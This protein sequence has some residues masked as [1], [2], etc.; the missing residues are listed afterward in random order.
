MSGE[1]EIADQVKRAKEEAEATKEA[2]Q[3]GKALR[4]R[5]FPSLFKV[6]DGR[7]WRE[8]E[9]EEHDGEVRKRWVPFGSEIRILAR[10]RTNAGEDHGLYLEVIDCDGVAHPW[11]MPAALLAGSGESIRAELLR[12]GFRPMHSAGRKWRDWLY[13]YLLSAD[14]EE[15]ARCVSSIGWHGTVFVLPDE[16]FSAGGEPERVVLQSAPPLNHAYRIQ[17]TLEDWRK[18]VA[19]PA[20]GNSRLILA[21]SAAFASPL[22]ALTDRSGFGL[23]LRGASSVGKST[24]LQVA[25]SVWGGGAPRDYVRSW[26]AT[27]NALEAVSAMHD[28]TI[29]CLDELAQVEPKAAGQA[30][31]ML[32]DGAGKMRAG[33]EGQARPGYTWRLIFLS[34][35]E[36][37]LADK[38]KEGD[39]QNAAGMEVRLVD[40]RADAGKSLGLFEDIHGAQD[41]GIFAQNISAA[42]RQYYGTAAREFLR[43]VVADLDKVKQEL[44]GLSQ[45]FEA[46]ALQENPG[47]DGQV[48]RVAAR[49]ALIAAAGDV[50]SALGI[51]GWPVGTAREACLR[52]FKDWLTERGG[53]GSGEEADARRRLIEAIETYGASRFQKWHVNSDRAVITPRWGFVK[54]HA[55]GEEHLESYQF[56]LTGPALKE[57]L[58]GLDFRAMVAALLG[59]GIVSQGAKAGSSKV[60]H[61]PN[62]GGKHRL[63]Q[64]DQD[65]LAGGESHGDE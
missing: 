19:S 35:G 13:E 55:E 38:I 48:K 41:A 60:F 1:K 6:A 46:V 11:S 57:I 22:L 25:A 26:R 40:L 17:G 65:A 49:F 4:K 14:P 34:T 33:K 47:A 59:K 58:R 20:L 28:G 43:Y 10:T 27:D 16:T 8:V 12:L 9:A 32:A 37:S 62:A 2:G 42:A 44:A 18:C 15:R 50:A 53:T 54:T 56:F 21:I 29:M 23:H 39:R 24:A 63:Y 52:L 3:R 61:V 51:T 30:A 64:I 31:Y 5:P 45:K 7:T 36:I